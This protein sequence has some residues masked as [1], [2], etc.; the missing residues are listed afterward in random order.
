MITV[1]DRGVLY[2]MTPIVGSAGSE[3]LF[4]QFRA[5]RASLFPG[6]RHDVLKWFGF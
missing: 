6:V 4:M 2:R 5:R 1:R 3:E